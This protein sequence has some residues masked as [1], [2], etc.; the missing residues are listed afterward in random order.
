MI[1]TVVLKSCRSSVEIICVLSAPMP[2]GTT[3]ATLLPVL[4]GVSEF[5]SAVVRGRALALLRPLAFGTVFEGRDGNLGPDP[6]LL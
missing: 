1:V 2:L 4:E 5:G 3:L 6:G